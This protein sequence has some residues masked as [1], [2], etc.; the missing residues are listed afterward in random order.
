MYGEG[1]GVS[2]CPW[3]YLRHKLGQ[4]TN[5]GGGTWREAAPLGP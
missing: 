4:L 5:G 1:G 2:Y 3:R